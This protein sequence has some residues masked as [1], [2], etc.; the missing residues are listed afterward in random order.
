MCTACIHTHCDCD[1]Q[2]KSVCHCVC[3]CVCLCPCVQEEEESSGSL[4]SLQ[5]AP[6]RIPT[7]SRN[8]ERFTGLTGERP[9]EKPHLGSR[10][11][12]DEG[13]IEGL[14]EDDGQER[15]SRNITRD[16][17]S[18]HANDP[19]AVHSAQRKSPE[20]HSQVPHATAA[21]RRSEPAV[22]ASGSGDG[23]VRREVGVREEETASDTESEKL[24]S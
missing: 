13:E 8:A 5:R 20:I 7:D 6:G 23:R 1:S 4:Q 17:E 22:L 21:H 12:P 15:D 11:D 10:E 24:L 19:V 3:V 16:K 2:L 18:H 14:G 9:V